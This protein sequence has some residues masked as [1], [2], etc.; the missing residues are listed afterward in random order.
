MLVACKAGDH[1]KLRKGQ[2][3][4]LVMCLN[5]CDHSASSQTEHT[6][7]TWSHLKP[8]PHSKCTA[9]N[10]STYLIAAALF[11]ENPLEA[12]WSVVSTKRKIPLVNRGMG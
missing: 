1:A 7:G 12:D 4:N 6:S 3:L 8:Q 11:R 10:F 5:C 2:C 9:C